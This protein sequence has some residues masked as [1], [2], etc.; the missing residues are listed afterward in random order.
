MAPDERVHTPGPK[1]RPP[2]R[3]APGWGGK[4]AQMDAAVGAEELGGQGGDGHGR[5][6]ATARSLDLELELPL[7]SEGE[8]AQPLRRVLVTG[9][10]PRGDGHRQLQLLDVV[11]VQ[12]Q[13]LVE[14]Q[15][16]VGLVT[17]L[18]GDGAEELLLRLLPDHGVD[19]AHARGE[20]R[21]DLADRAL[22]V[23]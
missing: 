4:A 19:L 7:Y 17:V 18:R 6:A 2:L 10:E 1:G 12:R 20:D 22:V 14:H 3:K 16:V 23:G 9:D 13:A 15:G 21:L 8:M 5:L 11:R